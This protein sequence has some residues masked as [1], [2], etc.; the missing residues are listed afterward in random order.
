MKDLHK[1]I[2]IQKDAKT[3]WS[4]LGGKPTLKRERG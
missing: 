1:A 4:S 3:N 2:H